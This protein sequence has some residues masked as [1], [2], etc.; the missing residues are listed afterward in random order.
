MTA[1]T[2]LQARL[3]VL[4]AAALFSTGGAAIKAS[5]LSAWQ[6]ASLRSGIAALT[7]L[8]L[9]PGARRR[10]SAA[11]AGVG[12]VY[13]S[14]MI[15]FV[16]A[17]KLTT[18][19]NAIF[20]QG[21]A[22]LYVLIASPIL[23]RERVRRADLW[24]MVALAIGLA[25]VFA[26]YE[27][28]RVSAPDPATGNL[29]ALGSG[30]TW[31]GTVIGLRWMGTRS[32][33]GTQPSLV[34]GNVIACAATLPLALPLTGLD[35]RDVLIVSFLGVF[36]I[37]LAYACLSVGI[38]G[39]RA[40]EASLLLLLEPVLNPVWSWLAHGERP[41]QWALAGGAIILVATAVR[42][43]ATPAAAEAPLSGVRESRGIRGTGSPNS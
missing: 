5:T 21:T 29:M 38:P 8:V 33:E 6:V 12:V 24:F 23:L 42:T 40:L 39:V 18:S 9:L 17:N 4:A 16:L 25:A 1:V 10:P 19:A 13:A 27:A 2:P 28:P 3:L 35:G 22:P 31:A 30:L 36:Q 26:G 15:L 43:L 37:G 11:A 34:I 41:G 7:L 32:G 14:T 20:L